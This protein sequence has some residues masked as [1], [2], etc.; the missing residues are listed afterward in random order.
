MLVPSD[1][2]SVARCGHFFHYLCWVG[3]LERSKSCPQ[4]RKKTTEKEIFR[5]YFNVAEG[6]GEEVDDAAAMNNKL[7]SLT[8]NLRVK[9]KD[10]T[11]VKEELQK[12]VKVSK[13]LREEIFKYKKKLDEADTYRQ[14]L[15]EKL[16]YLRAQSKE[17]EHAKA[18][19]LSLRTKLDRLQRM[20]TIIHGNVEDV[21]KVLENTN[22]SPDGMRSL[23]LFT[24]SLKRA[25]EEAK[26]RREQMRE[27]HNADKAE[28]RKVK[29]CVQEFKQALENADAAKQHL[30]GDIRHL[31]QEKKSLSEKIKHLE[32]AILSPG[33][34]NVKDKALRRLIAESPAPEFLKRMRDD[35]ENDD[36]ENCLTPVM[37]APGRSF[38]FSQSQDEN[39][40]SQRA[41]RIDLDGSP[42]LGVRPLIVKG[43]GV[44]LK[45]THSLPV[46]GPFN[47]MSIFNKRLQNTNQSAPLRPT[48]QHGAGYDGLG[49]HSKDDEFPTPIPKLLKKT[50]TSATAPQSKPK[51]FCA[52]SGVPKL[53][54]FDGFISLE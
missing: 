39:L 12:E 19:V 9:D 26:E 29:Q 38:S 48:S 28:L 16:T 41:K 8:F 7:D 5:L 15:E 50:K 44:P 25:L 37:A 35:D 22:F 49:G 4:C 54:E 52:P 3:W 51:N 2:V 32:K 31:E 34:D 40:A 14:C 20:D 33:A 45:K 21:E 1:D 10:L 18:E 42:A 30:E 43:S 23:A 13:G 27:A 36:L 11:T 17:A 46:N 24:S 53:S 47:K 6:E